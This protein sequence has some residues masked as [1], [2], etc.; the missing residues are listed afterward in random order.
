L[1]TR[2][3]DPVSDLQPPRK[4]SVLGF[5]DLVRLQV[6]HEMQMDTTREEEEMELEKECENAT[7]EKERG[8]LL[9]ERFRGNQKKFARKVF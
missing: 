6:S 4:V 9:G 2:V 3:G 5:A 8:A 1:L 7:L